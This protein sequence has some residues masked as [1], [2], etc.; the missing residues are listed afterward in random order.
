MHVTIR[1]LVC[2]VKP[3]FFFYTR[4]IRFKEKKEVYNSLIAVKPGLNIEKL[5]LSAVNLD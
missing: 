4:L 5:R 2:A 3:K 1:N